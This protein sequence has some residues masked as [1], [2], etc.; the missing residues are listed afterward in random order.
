MNRVCVFAHYDKDNIVEEYVLYYL[1]EL[2]KFF[3]K[4]VFVSDTDLPKTETLKLEKIC[5]YIQAKHHGQYDWGSY[6]F[7]YIIAKENGLLREADELLFCNDSV[8]GPI[9]DLDKCFSN[10][11]N[12]D[13]DICGMY[14]NNYGLEKGIKSP[15]LQSWFLLI[16]KNAFNSEYF[17]EFMLNITSQENKTDIIEKYEIGFSK[18][19]EQ[20]YKLDYIYTSE[21]SDIVTNSPLEIIKAGFPFLKANSL[22]RYNFNNYLKKHLNSGLYNAIRKHNNRFKKPNVVKLTFNHIKLLIKNRKYKLITNL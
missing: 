1:L 11:T 12:K 9:K 13:C 8:Y 10:M 18:H 2:K 5:D 7:G 14:Q 21:E 15:H 6:K 19:M 3:N 16:K 4:I 22:R 20:Y 17:N